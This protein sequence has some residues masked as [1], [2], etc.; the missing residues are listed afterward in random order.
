MVMKG[1]HVKPHQT[2]RRS[3]FQITDTGDSFQKT[4][5]PESV[6]YELLGSAYAAYT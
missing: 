1:Q 3:V 4:F 5:L 6:S 2:R